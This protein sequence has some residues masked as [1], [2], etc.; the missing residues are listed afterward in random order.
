MTGVLSVTAVQLSDP[1]GL[2]IL[3]KSDDRALQYLDS[4]D[5]DYIS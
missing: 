5:R 2:V 4:K 3:V 1:M